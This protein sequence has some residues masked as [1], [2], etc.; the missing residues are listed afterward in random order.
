MARVDPLV[1]VSFFVDVGDVFKGTF[2]GCSGLGS[3]SE[4]IE[5][6]TSGAGGTT[7]VYKIP[8][9]TRWTNIVLKRGVTDSMDVWA[10]RKQVEDGKVDEARKNGSIIMYDQTIT[11]VARWNFENGWP[12]KVS[13][14]ALKSDSNEFGVEELVVVHEGITRES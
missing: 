6:I 8:G 1:S 5:Y 12:S 10:W 7:H 3:G 4:V 11:E 9:V 2:R 13:G 14:P